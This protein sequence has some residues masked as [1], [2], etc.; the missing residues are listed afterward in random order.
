MANSQ[1][2]IRLQVTLKARHINGR[3]SLPH[4]LQGTTSCTCVFKCLGFALETIRYFACCTLQLDAEIFL[5]KIVGDLRKDCLLGS[6]KI[7]L[8]PWFGSFDRFESE[9]IY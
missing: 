8:I 6:P 4:I 5:A 3:G 1:D 7:H 9:D 2:L